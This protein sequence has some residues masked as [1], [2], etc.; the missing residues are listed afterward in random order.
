MSDKKIITTLKS[1]QTTDEEFTIEGYGSIYTARDRDG[2]IVEQGAFTKYLSQLIEAG[3][4]LPMCFNHDL[5]KVLGHWIEIREDSTGLY[6]K[7]RFNKDVPSAVDVY[8]LVKG[9]SINGLSIGVLVHDF[10]RDSE[11]LILKELELFEISVVTAPCHRETRITAVKSV[12]DRNEIPDI[13]SVEKALREMGFSRAQAKSILSKGYSSLSPV[14]DTPIAISPE[15]IEIRK[16][17][18]TLRNLML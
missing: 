6:I 2:D 14:I 9:G 1:I 18:E 13:T 7:G 10:E 5:D 17:L 11:G 3:D 12:L 4:P 16:S 15:L 8:N